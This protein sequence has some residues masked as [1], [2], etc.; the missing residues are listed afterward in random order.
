VPHAYGGDP[1]A[2]ALVLDSR[3]CKGADARVY[4]D[5]RATNK[6]CIVV[7]FKPEGTPAS[8][9]SH[10]G[11]LPAGDY[12]LTA[13]L[14]PQPLPIQHGLAVTIKANAAVRRLAQID[15]DGTLGPIPGSKLPVS[16]AGYQPFTL[17]F[18][19]AGGPVAVSIVASPSASSRRR[20]R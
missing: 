1:P 2:P 8:L 19:H 5:E 10:K 7:L 6:S 17:A 12:L 14:E 4:R 18:T 16:G 20:R 9:F 13:W 15:F 3:K 11:A